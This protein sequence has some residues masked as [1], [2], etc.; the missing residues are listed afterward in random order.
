[1]KIMGLQKLTLLDFPGRAACTVFTGGCSFRCPFCHNASLVECRGDQ[2]SLDEL[3]AFLK[4]RQGLLDGV[5][6]TGG[7]PLLQAN[8]KEFIRAIKAL[9]YSVKLDTNGYLPEKLGE[10]LEEGLLDYVAMDVK[11]SPTEYDKAS[12][13]K[14]DLSRIEKSMTL[15]RTG[16]VPYEF[17]TTVVKG[18]HTEASLT[19][20]AQTLE[21]NDR[22]Y[23]QQY[24]DSGDILGSGCEPFSPETMQYLAEKLQKIHKNTTLRGL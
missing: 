2:I 9:G 18:I 4:K 16:G 1:M 10:L 20:L 5:A 13:V 8:L 14:T 15:L 22:W 23:L 24:V 11:N 19:E 17:R 3:M 6:I 7:E 21:Q 12:G